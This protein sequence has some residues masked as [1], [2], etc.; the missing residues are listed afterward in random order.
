MIE[1]ALKNGANINARNELM[2]TAFHD[3]VNNQRWEVA[4]RLLEVPG[5]DCDAVDFM[6]AT[7]LM[8]SCENGN[9]AMVK[10]LVER[11]AKPDR[12]NDHG[13]TALSRAGC[14]GHTGVVEYLLKRGC[15][16]NIADKWGHT[17]LHKACMR[18][19][20][21]GIVEL[22]LAY[23]ANPHA[24]KPYIEREHWHPGDFVQDS[25]TVLHC[26]A[27][28]GSRRAVR[29]LLDRGVRLDKRNHRGETVLHIA[30]NRLWLSG[31]RNKEG[32]RACE[33]IQCEIIQELIEG[34]ANM[35]LRDNNDR[36][37]Y[38]DCGAIEAG[39]VLLLAYKD[40]VMNREGALAV[41]AILRT[42][43]YDR[44]HLSV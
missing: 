44:R 32:R 7:P 39:K 30:A 4:S 29:L 19:D 17:N 1:Q 11:G 27:S 3:A 10:Q 43:I 16:P 34:G 15:N 40:Q 2:R 26:A 31:G 14:N 24:R 38:D 28:R 9:L 41:H 21:D 12:Q 13:H 20:K 35:L 33:V 25:P 6:G 8:D 22:L 23:G 42:T 5:I 18:T 36:T 37:P